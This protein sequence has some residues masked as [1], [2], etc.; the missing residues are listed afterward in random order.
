MQ[1]EKSEGPNLRAL[2]EMAME[3][4]LHERVRRCR[5]FASG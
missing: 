1:I 5:Q 4:S 3:I 2:K